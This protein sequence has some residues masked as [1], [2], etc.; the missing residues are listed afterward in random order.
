M[1]ILCFVYGSLNC[2][3]FLSTSAFCGCVF[4]LLLGAYTT[5]GIAESYGN[6]VLSVLRN[7]QAICTVAAP[8]EIPVAL[9]VSQFSLLTNIHYLLKKLFFKNVFE[10]VTE[11]GGRVKDRYSSAGS[12]PKARSFLQG[13]HMGA[14]PSTWA[15][16]LFF[17]RHFN[18]ELGLK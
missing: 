17:P 3:Y 4:L 7:Y 16:P 8:F 10:R 1:D 12:L 13:F 15:H 18:G 5:S 6:Y 14:G 9:T 2:F 11:M